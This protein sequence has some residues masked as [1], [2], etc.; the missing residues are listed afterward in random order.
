MSFKNSC[1]TG[2]VNSEAPQA[3]KDTVSAFIDKLDELYVKHG[4]F[5]EFLLSIKFEETKEGKE[6]MAAGFKNSEFV[7]G[8]QDFR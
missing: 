6:K 5:Y 8:L 3:I 4:V 7:P 2:I 1:K